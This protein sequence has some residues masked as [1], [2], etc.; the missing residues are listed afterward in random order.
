MQFVLSCGC[1]SSAWSVDRASVNTVVCRVTL[2]FCH[3]FQLPEV[4]QKFVY[5]RKVVNFL[6][7][8]L[9]ML[10]KFDTISK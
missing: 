4:F 2:V 1:T 6:A 5:V 3:T 7:V 8:F 10:W 9:Q